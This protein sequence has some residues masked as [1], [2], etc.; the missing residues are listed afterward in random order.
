MDQML[1]S[2]NNHPKKVFQEGVVSRLYREPVL[3]E[4]DLTAGATE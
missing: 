4:I 2:G 3:D 1:Y